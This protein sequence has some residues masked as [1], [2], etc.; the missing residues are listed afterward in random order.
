MSFPVNEAH[1][2]MALLLQETHNGTMQC[3]FLRRRHAMSFSMQETHNVILCE[4]NAQ[5]D[6]LY[7]RRSMSFTAEVG[8]R[9]VTGIVVETT[10]DPVNDVLRKIEFI[11]GRSPLVCITVLTPSGYLLPGS[12]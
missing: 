8:R 1:N 9:A 4:R 5:Y 10:V 7:Q 12:K 11:S 2:A 3:H 6:S